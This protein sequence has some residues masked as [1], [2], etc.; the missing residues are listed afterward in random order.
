M[1]DPARDD[2]QL[3]WTKLDIAIPEMDRQAAT[4]HEEEIIGLLVPMP[5]ERPEGLHDLELVVVD[6]ADDPRL[7]GVGE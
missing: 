2:E 5:D 7:I 3:T 4:D 1:L 6:V